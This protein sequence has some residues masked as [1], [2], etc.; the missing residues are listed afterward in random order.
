[1]DAEL[2][3]EGGGLEPWGWRRRF[4][5]GADFEDVVEQE[6]VDYAEST[7]AHAI[8]DVDIT[9]RN[10]WRRFQRA[11]REVRFLWLA[12]VCLLGDIACQFW[13]G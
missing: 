13:Q 12:G 9:Y 3:V 11:S 6:A 2:L 7:D 4:S 5:L 1:M 8:L 10:G